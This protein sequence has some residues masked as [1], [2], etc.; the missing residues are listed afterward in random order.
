MYFLC[1]TSFTH[2]DVFEIDPCCLYHSSFFFITAW[3]LIIL[4]YHFKKK[5]HLSTDKHMDSFPALAI[6][7]NAEVNIYTQVLM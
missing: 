2:H 5:I 6:V 7:N 4:I 1:L 3:F